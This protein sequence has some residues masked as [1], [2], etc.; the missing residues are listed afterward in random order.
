MWTAQSS[1]PLQNVTVSCSTAAG[2][3]AYLAVA[4]FTGADM[5]G[6]NGSAAIGATGTNNGTANDITAMVTTTRANSWVWGVASD[7]SGGS[8]V[9]IPKAI[10][11]NV[12]SYQFEDT[13]FLV[14]FIVLSQALPTS[15]SSTSITS[16]ATSTLSGASMK[17][18][19]SV[20]EI[21]PAL[22]PD[23]T[24]QDLSNLFTAH[25]YSNASVDDGDYFVQT[26]SKYI[27]TEFK[28]QSPNN[29]NN[30]QVIWKGRTTLAPS[31]SR[32]FLQIFNQNSSAWETL[33]SQSVVSVDT[34]F[35]LQGTQNTNVANY[36]DSTNTV[37][38]RVYQLVV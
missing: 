36:Y 30:I 4:V 28:R 11:N 35:I 9:D 23:S 12:I 7:L 22:P 20:V 38:C 13:A 29:S 1:A 24:S 3:D 18:N 37:S 27:I 2:N 33:G 19:F 16:A 34:D 10:R 21:L 14:T 25:Q 17:Y 6:T 26:G 32:V 31:R 15:A 8:G 5:S